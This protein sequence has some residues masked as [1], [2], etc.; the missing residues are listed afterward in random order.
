MN[1]LN[2]IF[3]NAIH[4]VRSQRDAGKWDPVCIKAEIALPRKSA[5]GKLFFNYIY[6]DLDK[7]SICVVQA[8]LIVFV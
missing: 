1:D 8:T 2:Q 5:A 7:M 3:L 4:L 6:P